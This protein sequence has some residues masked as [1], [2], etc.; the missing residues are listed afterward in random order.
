MKGASGKMQ[1]WF[2]E[3]LTPTAQALSLNPQGVLDLALGEELW[4]SKDLRMLDDEG[5]LARNWQLEW[6]HALHQPVRRHLCEAAIGT[7]GPILEIAA[8]PGG[9]NLSPLLHLSPHM[10]LIINDLER[11]IVERWQRFLDR[12]YPNVA[13]AAFDA[14]TMPLK[15][16]SMGCVSS[17]GGISNCRGDANAVLSECARVLKPGGLLILYEMCLSP[18]TLANLPQALREAWVMN[19]WMYGD[20]PGLLGANSFSVLYDKVAE[21]KTW[22]PAE[23]GLAYDASKFG[24]EVELDFRGVIAEVRK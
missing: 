20:W 16:N 3:L 24:V 19:E 18:N 6:E 5:W 15:E 23:S 11:R 4:S 8:G 7:G 2:N 22:S 13:Y 17:R 12:S 1:P 14:S 21:R 9:G 10:K